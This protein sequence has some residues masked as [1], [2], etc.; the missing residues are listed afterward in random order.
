MRRGS[1]EL[2]YNFSENPVSMAIP[3]NSSLLLA[4]DRIAPRE[5]AQVTVPSLGFAAFSIG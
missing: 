2:L 3:A 4:S 5:G 1:I